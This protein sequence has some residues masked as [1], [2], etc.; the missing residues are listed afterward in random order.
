MT[1]QSN[2]GPGSETGASAILVALALVLLLGMAALAVDIG[3]GL[4][5]RRIDVASADMSVM[6][7]A[8]DTVNGPTQVISEALD[9]ARLNLPTTYTAGQWQTLWEGCVDPA[10]ERN[11]GP[12]TFV[13][14]NP[15]GIG[16]TPSQ[17]SDWCISLDPA[18]GLLRVRI[19]DQDVPTTF[20]RV[21]GATTIQTHAAAV[22][23]LVTR[24]PGGVLPFGLPSS[25]GGGDH[26]CLSSAPTGNALDPC[27]G[28]LTGNFGTLKARQFGNTFLG[29][30]Q[31]CT[32]SPLGQTL[33]QNIATGIDHLIVTDPDGVAA[34]EVRDEC[35]NPFV[36]T[37]NTD[38]GFPNN[39]A[40]EGLIGPVAG[41]FT[42][43]LQKNGPFA[44]VFNGEQIN[45]QPLWGF[46][47]GSGPDYGGLATGPTADDAP[48]SCNPTTFTGS[49][50]I[51]F[52]GN[53]ISDDIDG[54]GPD[55]ATSWQHMAICFRQYLG[56]MDFNGSI[57]G[58]PSSVEIFSLSVADN[59]S[60]FAYVPQ[61]WESTLGT[62]NEWNHIQRFRAV[63]LQSTGWKNG[64]NY[65]FHNP[66]ENCLPACNG[67]GYSLRQLSAFTFPDLALPEILRGNPP[68]GG[69]VNPLLPELFR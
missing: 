53:G 57:E 55:T 60:R 34:N 52:D 43:R 69:G 45:D 22:A 4:R 46:L 15:N 54:N 62:G 31:N 35:V 6:A 8:I 65:E 26:L 3:F 19:P 2:L 44:S 5:E 28:S 68:F 7:G 14:L 13:A 25:A 51:D 9:F 30:L 17:P 27:A 41:G 47:L 48:A 29:T 36:D 32:A 11:F 18:H 61:F 23:R 1:R 40:E 10:S 49:G 50:A 24:S 66:G 39:G 21:L 59:A 67:N 38:T 58:S 16:W 56:D 20:A 63:Y 12:Y 64:N 37:L 33:A 42:P